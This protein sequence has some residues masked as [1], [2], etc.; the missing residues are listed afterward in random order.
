MTKTNITCPNCNTRLSKTRTKH[1]YL[2][3]LCN[4]TWVKRGKHLDRNGIHDKG[5]YLLE[6]Y[7][8]KG[9]KH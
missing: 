9:D 1:T 3:L 7:L 5:E 4:D 8:I 2:C 6:H